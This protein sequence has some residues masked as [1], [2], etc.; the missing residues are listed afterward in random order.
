MK[1]KRFILT[2]FAI[3]MVFSTTTIG[4]GV[5]KAEALT[6]KGVY[7]DTINWSFNDGTGELTIS[8]TGAITDTNSDLPWRDYMYSVKSINISNG[9]TSINES[10]FRLYENLEKVIISGNTLTEINDF[11]FSGC[12]H[13]ES[14]TL[15]DSL[16]HIGSY[17]LL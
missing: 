6:Y 11:A 7:N 3:A 14:I 8:G 5:L 17:L 9:I 15:P 16:K 4:F 13:L 12:G 2:V 1:L 10:S